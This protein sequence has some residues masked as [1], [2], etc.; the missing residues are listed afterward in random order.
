M[1]GKRICIPSAL[2]VRV[3]EL[4]HEGHQGEI[5]TK[6]LL[7]SCVWFPDM[8]KQVQK[9]VK[10]CA[11]CL[12]S[13]STKARTPLVMSKMPEKA[14]TELSMDFYTIP[15]FTELLVVI[16]DFSRF[17]VVVPTQST[18]FKFVEEKLIDILSTFGV[19]VVIRTDNFTSPF[20]GKDFAAFA[21]RMGFKHCKVT[22]AWPKANGEAERFMRTLSKVFRTASAT[23][24]NWMVQ[25]ND[26]LRNYRLTPHPATGLPP[27]ELL[28]SRLP[29][30]RLPH[31]QQHDGD[32]KR[33]IQE[34]ADKRRRVQEHYLQ[35]GDKVFVVKRA[36][37]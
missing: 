30:S 34:A 15:D 29:S 9:F 33:R 4:A 5:R 8:D 24:V 32:Y 10:D 1:R 16:D 11:A 3:I 26:F 17:P 2:Q 37:C 18:A 25:V 27:S 23:G 19:P 31:L 14:W 28:F 7:C 21:E 36:I 13:Q 22:Y 6:Q 20:N 35:V 12:V